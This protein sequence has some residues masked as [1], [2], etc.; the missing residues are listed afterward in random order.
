MQCVMCGKPYERNSGT[1]KYCS[2]GCAR[3]AKR[4]RERARFDK[5]NLRRICVICGAKFTTPRQTAAITCGPDCAN[6]A[7]RKAATSNSRR[8]TVRSGLLGRPW[9]PDGQD[10]FT[11][12]PI[13]NT[14]QYDPMTNRMECEGV[15]IQTPEQRE[16]LRKAKRRRG[17]R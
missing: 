15:W 1:Q 11:R 16:Q 5:K 17:A 6:E 10:W 2:P 4:I 13:R 3:E 8:Y 9:V 14:P 12:S 7:R